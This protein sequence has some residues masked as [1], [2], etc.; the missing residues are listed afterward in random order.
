MPENR[1]FTNQELKQ[2]LSIS[3]QGQEASH[4]SVI[5]RK[6]K[7]DTVEIINGKG[8]LSEAK[9]LEISEKKATLKIEKIYFEKEKKQKIILVQS[10]I[11]PNKLELILEKC[12]ELGVSEFWMF[13]SK[14]SQKMDFS[15]N[16]IER[17]E[18]ILISAIKQCGR[19]YL[20]KMKFLNTKEE[21]KNAEGQLFLG[22][23]AKESKKLI[24]SDI[25][26]ENNLFFIIGPESGF[27][28]DEILFFEQSIKAMPI[29]LNEN[30]LRSETA[31]ISS[32]AI[33]S[34]LLQF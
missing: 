11:K 6:K 31:A 5:M 19:L 18:K 30:I 13:F 3:L 15:E 14:H 28:E 33:L 20:P 7:N 9:I 12:T 27:T 4:M 10:V 1:Y 17:F 25:K 16:R 8:F 29:K 34:H 32:I 26:N 24:D 23:V 22:S 21:L 2:N